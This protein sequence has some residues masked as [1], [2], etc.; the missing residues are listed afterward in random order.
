MRDAELGPYRTEATTDPI[1]CPQCGAPNR[2]GAK[3]CKQCGA[4]FPTLTMKACPQCGTTNPMDARA[5]PQCGHVFG[6]GT[7][8]PPPLPRVRVPRLLFWLG[9]L[10]ALGLGLCGLVVLALMAQPGPAVTPAAATAPLSA[11]SSLT[12]NSAPH[13]PLGAVVRIIIPVDSKPDYSSTGSGSII[14]RHGHI[15]TNL[16]LL[17]DPDTGELYNAQGEIWIGIT[18]DPAAPA[19][20]SYL[21]K[22]VKEDSQLDLALLKITED[23][24]GRALPQN[25]NF[26]AM[27]IG[28]SDQLLVGDEVT[29]L[30]YPGLGGNTLTLTRGTVAGFLPNKN[31]IKTDA[32]INSGNSGGA[33]L[34]HED[35]LIGIPTAGLMPKDAGELPGKLGLIRPINL[36]KSLIDLAKR[37]AGE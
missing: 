29:V 28:N 2:Y 33:A 36:A 31:W 4:H 16:H 20:V 30:G 19:Q 3:F 11:S 37:E 10:V 21:A 27:L 13:V 5:C 1:P 22:L 25:P 26:T 17:R 14:T 35:E 24:N 34:N 23:K 8:V 32:E 15:L 6:H 9:V 12:P 7:A 18:T